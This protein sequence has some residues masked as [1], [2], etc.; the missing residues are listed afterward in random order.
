MT[1]CDTRSRLTDLLSEGLHEDRLTADQNDQARALLDLG[2]RLIYRI[3]IGGFAETWLAEE[4]STRAEVVIKLL[5]PDKQGLAYAVQRLEQEGAVLQSLK[6]PGVVRL[7]SRGVLE[8]TPYLVLDF[9]DSDPLDLAFRRLDRSL[10][11]GTLLRLIESVAALHE[12][13]ITHGDLK[14]ANILAD[15]R[16]HITLIDFGLA[17][18]G[19]PG[20]RLLRNPACAGT[21]GFIA[22]ELERSELHH[23]GPKSDVYALGVILRELI[24]R[25]PDLPRRQRLERLADRATSGPDSR[26][27]HAGQLVE[28]VRL[29]NAPRKHYALKTA[30]ALFLAAAA[31]IPVLRQQDSEPQPALSAVYAD[32]ETDPE[33]ASKAL[34]RIVPAQRSWLWR[35]LG[36]RLKADGAWMELLQPIEAN[37]SVFST[38]AAGTMVWMRR[39]LQSLGFVRQH[40]GDQQRWA[41]VTESPIGAIALDA[42][43]ERLAVALIDGRVR[44]YDVEDP[45]RPLRETRLDAKP[46]AIWFDES[47]GLLTMIQSEPGQADA[48]AVLSLGGDLSSRESLLDDVQD[49]VH[50][51]G[52]WAARIRTSEGSVLGWS[53]N[54]GQLRRIS[55][56]RVERRA[57]IVSIATD[58]NRLYLGWS[59]RLISGHGGEFG[60]GRS[61]VRHPGVPISMAASPE[62]ELFVFASATLWAYA[63][64]EFSKPVTLATSDEFMSLRPGLTFDETRQALTIN[65]SSGAARW[66]ALASH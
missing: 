17:E 60:E 20:M 19:D 21:D 5:R 3:A 15:G 54:D 8:K 41:E 65:T 56:E 35:H 44:L 16:G 11:L 48:Y 62:G 58:G 22:P 42:R 10:L 61:L 4:R 6:H 37:D 66:L 33:A 59:D 53:R 28:V 50:A 45:L 38:Q 25:R 47:L 9:I 23:M 12:R 1:L 26:P 7:R 63:P 49:V 46:R 18:I 30:A 51:S 27:S 52:V 24:R 29:L 43:G 13:G 36:Y 34:D 2:Y 57:R 31:L 39:D 40:Q 64:G 14:P 32:L 55:G